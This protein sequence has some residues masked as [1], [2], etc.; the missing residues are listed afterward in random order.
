MQRLSAARVAVGRGGAV[1][2]GEAGGALVLAPIGRVLVAVQIAGIAWQ[3]SDRATSTLPPSGGQRTSKRA[4]PQGAAD[5]GVGPSGAGD[6]TVAAVLGRVE[7]RAE[8]VVEAVLVAH[9]AC[10]DQASIKED[11]VQVR[12]QVPVVHEVDR[13]PGTASQVAP[14]EPQCA[15][16]LRVWQVLLQEV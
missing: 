4:A 6:A 9:H 16:V 1:G 5:R 12:V 15:L 2:A 10:C 13:E 8:V 14:H 11:H 7:R 3:G